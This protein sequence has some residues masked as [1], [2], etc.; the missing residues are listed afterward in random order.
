MGL[1]GNIR[2]LVR[3]FQ[4]P[5]SD[6]IG[7]AFDPFGWL[8]A[9][10]PTQIPEFAFSEGSDDDD[11]PLVRRVMAAYSAANADFVPSESFWDKSI[12]RRNSDIHH[13]LSGADESIAA[14]KLRDPASNAHFW[15][16]DIIA[17]APEG[18]MEPHKNFLVHLNKSMDWKKL[19]AILIY[20]MLTSVADALGARRLTNAEIPKWLSF[21]AP[22]EILDNIEAAI[23]QPLEFP[24]P[25]RGEIGLPTRRGVVSYRALHGL[26][27]GWRIAQFARGNRG[28][29]VLEI[30]A[31]LGRNAYF[32]NRFGVEDYTII[33]IPMTGAAQGY[34]LGRVLGQDK[35]RLHGESDPAA[36]SVVPASQ[37]NK[38]EGRFDLI[39]NVDSFTELAGD[40]VQAYWQFAKR[41]AGTMLSINHES[42]ETTVRDLYAGDA[43]V[44]VE[45]YPYWLRRGYVEEIIQFTPPAAG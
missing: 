23:G 34:F 21:V 29:R 33:D 3:S 45:R 30:G 9:R 15:G 39:V 11:E 38:L 7:F 42:N 35:V 16:F 40:V 2:R 17:K 4:T 18:L 44:T 10:D 12:L 27:Q 25:Y 26:Y 41:S 32:A 31:G 20:D 24:N 13:A 37:L 22:D 1:R 14:G 36:V 5:P 19:H 8:L 6:G 28:F 43:E